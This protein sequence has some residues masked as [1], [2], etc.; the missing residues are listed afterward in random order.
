MLEQDAPDLLDGMRVGL[1]G[2]FGPH[3]DLGGH[4]A[5]RL[6]FRALLKSFHQLDFARLPRLFEIELQRILL[7][8]VEFVSCDRVLT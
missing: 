8:K 2:V 1:D 7:A 6:F 3:D 4:A 5:R